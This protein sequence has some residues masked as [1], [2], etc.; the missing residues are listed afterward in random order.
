MSRVS[1]KINPSQAV[2]DVLLE[3]VRQLSE[4]GYDAK[5]DD[6]HTDGAIA[7]AAA[8]YIGGALKCHDGK[9][10]GPPD[11]Q[12]DDVD[13]LMALAP[14]SIRYKSPRDSLVKATALIL[15]EIERID[16]A[17]R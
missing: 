11:G 6:A 12:D 16:R 3:R 17:A 9:K 10:Y 14:W 8:A 2:Q 5:H 1:V 4:E 13:V 15:A 7:L